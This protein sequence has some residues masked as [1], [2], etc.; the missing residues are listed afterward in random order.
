M[1]AIVIGGGLIH[2]EAFGHGEPWLAWLVAL[3]DAHDGG[4]R[5]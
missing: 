5:F 2:Y 1:S 3:L 4:T